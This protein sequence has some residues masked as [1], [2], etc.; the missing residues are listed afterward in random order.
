MANGFA[1]PSTYLAVI[2][3]QALLSAPRTVGTHTVDPSYDL[4]A[5]GVVR[6]VSTH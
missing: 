2:D 4:L 3:L 1:I 6:Y 5:H